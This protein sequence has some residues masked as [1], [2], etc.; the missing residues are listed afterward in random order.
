MTR[1]EKTIEAANK[2]KE[3]IDALEAENSAMKQEIEDAWEAKLKEFK[4]KLQPVVDAF[5][6]DDYAISG[7]VIQLESDI[8]YNKYEIMVFIDRHEDIAIGMNGVKY[9]LVSVHK[10][11]ETS[12]FAYEWMIHLLRDLDL[13]V[14]NLEEDFIRRYTIAVDRR[15]KN[16]ATNNDIIRGEWMKVKR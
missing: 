16:A 10:L 6:N 13:S 5:R 7:N 4:A 3:A 14:K 8:D 11:K 12:Q 1:L 9:E 2:A 15:F